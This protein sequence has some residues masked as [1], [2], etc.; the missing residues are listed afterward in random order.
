M[1]EMSV[2]ATVD[3]GAVFSPFSISDRELASRDSRTPA[4]WMLDPAP[5]PCLHVNRSHP[6]PWQKYRLRPA[7]WQVGQGTWVSYEVR[8]YF[9]AHL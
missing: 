2:A 4:R 6:A 5:T 1:E 7:T 9:D 8:R 3:A